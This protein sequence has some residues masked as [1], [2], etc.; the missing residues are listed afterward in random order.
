[1]VLRKGRKMKDYA[2]HM[3]T[4]ENEVR[5]LQHSLPMQ[6]DADSIKSIHAIRAC[7]NEIEYQLHHKRINE[8]QGNSVQLSTSETQKAD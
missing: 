4:I 8:K 1:M 6:H 5:K 3:V 2:E 7:I